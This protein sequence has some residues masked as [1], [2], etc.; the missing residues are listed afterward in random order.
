[1]AAITVTGEEATPSLAG[2]FEVLRTAPELA[3]ER[4]FYETWLAAPPDKTL[5]LV[6]EMDDITP[7]GQGPVIYACPMHPDVTSAPPGHC[8]ECGMKLLA[9][10][11][12]TIYACPMHPE[13]TSSEPGRCPQCGMKLLATAVAAAYACP[14]HPEVTS[15]EPG[16]CPQCG[17]KLLVTAVA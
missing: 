17:M 14:M 15:S 9:T 1:L 2:Q 13:V 6:A 3:A 12:A 5:A 8:P 11:T 16:R 4:E 7:P 10:V